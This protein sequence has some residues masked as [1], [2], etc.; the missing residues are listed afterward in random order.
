EAQ[1]TAA[2]SLALQAQH[3]AFLDAGRHFDIDLPAVDLQGNR[4]ALGR[5]QEGYRNLALDLLRRFGSPAAARPRPAAEDVAG[6]GLAAKELAKE[7]GSLARIHLLKA[8]RP[9]AP[10]K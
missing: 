9:A 8:A 4:A 10:V 5:R 2:G 3:L 7:I 1:V 6:V